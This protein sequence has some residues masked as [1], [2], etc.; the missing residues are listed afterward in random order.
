MEVSPRF[1]LRGLRGSRRESLLC[2]TAPSRPI[3]LVPQRHI[4]QASTT[5]LSLEC[6]IENIS[7]LLFPR[8]F[9]MDYPTIS[10]CWAE[11]GLAASPSSR[12]SLRESEEAFRG[13]DNTFREYRRQLLPWDYFRFARNRSRIDVKCGDH[14]LQRDFGPS[15][16]SRLAH[17]PEID[18]KVAVRS[19]WNSARLCP[20]KLYFFSK[21]VPK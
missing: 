20:S 14:F 1:R 3:K 4:I 9:T 7:D 12:T 8:P 16:A 18:G 13:K 6:S 15:I 21:W 17:H 5:G 11:I 2:C 10:Y 19:R